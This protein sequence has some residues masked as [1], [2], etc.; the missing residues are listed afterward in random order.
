MKHIN[1]ALTSLCAILALAGV[2][3]AN[4]SS[5][6][7][8]GGA[9][10]IPEGSFR[11]TVEPI[12]RSETLLVQRLHIRVA[13]NPL[14]EIHDGGSV[15]QIQC[16]TNP[17]TG[18]G[19]ATLT[20]VASLA[21]LP[22]QDSGILVWRKQ[23]QTTGTTLGGEQQKSLRPLTALEDQVALSMESGIYPLRRE[24]PIGVVRGRPCVL[25]LK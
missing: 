3:C 8:Y 25:T 10:A 15:N 7:G 6:P 19:E 11:M 9:E 20:L 21:S 12:I 2:A 24:I 5:S 23:L 17:K 4:R 14:L 22:G 18:F 1:R 16:K 13:T